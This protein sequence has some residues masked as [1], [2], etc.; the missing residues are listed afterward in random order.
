MSKILI[1]TLRSSRYVSVSKI[2]NG[3]LVPYNKQVN[4]RLLKLG[5]IIAIFICI[6]KMKIIQYFRR[7]KAEISLKENN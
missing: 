1:N 6:W 2:T 5:L 4:I 7:I 3:I